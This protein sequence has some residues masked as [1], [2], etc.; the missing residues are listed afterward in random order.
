MKNKKLFIFLPLIALTACNSL[1]KEISESDAND[2]SQAIVKKQNSAQVYSFSMK[3]VINTKESK[4]TANYKIVKDA[5]DNFMY[6][7]EEKGS[8]GYQSSKTV[9]VFKPSEQET[10]L[11]V[12]AYSSATNKTT[13]E[14]YT[15]FGK[16]DEFEN[17][18][19]KQEAF[20]SNLDS[21]FGEIQ[22]YQSYLPG[23][24]NCEKNSHYY[25]TGEGN[26]TAKLS[27]TFT[28]KQGSDSLKTINRTYKYSKDL[29][30][31]F[32]A[33]YVTF[34]GKKK[35]ESASVSYSNV[36]VNTPTDWQEHV[37]TSVSV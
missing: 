35:T 9:Y 26:L 15:K 36:K 12:K 28:D 21:S 10:V 33:T 31:N 11:Y 14:A 17:A 3:S 19:S 4:D 7:R 37:M 34:E 16:V 1:G 30:V 6:S 24:N 29:L 20:I 27:F 25:S 5:S 18:L 22:F 13:I 23:S 2:K 8:D 32:N